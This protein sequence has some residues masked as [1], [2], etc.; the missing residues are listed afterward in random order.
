MHLDFLK[1]NLK[2]NKKIFNSDKRVAAAREPSLFLTVCAGWGQWN[3]LVCCVQVCMP[4]ATSSVGS[5]P[6]P[7]L[8]S[9]MLSSGLHA[10][11]EASHWLQSW[12][13]VVGP[14]PCTGSGASPW[15]QT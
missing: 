12:G 15:S 9:S 14:M 6:C 3:N 4:N 10:G 2:G 1:R 11:P 13:G 5:K 7:G 8:G